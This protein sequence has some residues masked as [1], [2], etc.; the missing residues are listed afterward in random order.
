MKYHKL[1]NELRA[2]N[3]NLFKHK[4]PN[5]KIDFAFSN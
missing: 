1:Y 4:K 3:K 2:K 5:G